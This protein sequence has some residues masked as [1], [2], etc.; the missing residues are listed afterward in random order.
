MKRASALLVLVAALGCRGQDRPSVPP[1][2]TTSDSIRATPSPSES[3]PQRAAITGACDSAIAGVYSD[4]KTS[5][6]TGDV[7]GV[8]VKLTCA[9]GTYTAAVTVAEGA[10][11]DPVEAPAQVHDTTVHI[12]FPP[13]SPLGAIE[14][15][16]GVVTRQRFVGRFGNDE[17]VDLPR[18]H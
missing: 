18:R 1:S 4:I 6:E 2:A 5:T 14:T 9:A 16:K 12:T 8:E 10:L 7:G 11:A 15:L 17:S 13:D 3:A